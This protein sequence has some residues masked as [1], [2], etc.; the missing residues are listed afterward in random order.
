MDVRELAWA[1]GLF[2]ADGCISISTV[3][4]SPKLRHPVL[5]LSM[6]DE[7]AVR[8]FHRAVGG[9]GTIHHRKPQREGW[10]P[11]LVWKANSF[12]HAQAV[13]A[14][15]WYG[16]N[17]RRRARAAEVFGEVQASQVYRMRMR[18]GPECAEDDCSNPVLAK[19]LCSTHY[20]RRRAAQR[21]RTGS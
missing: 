8:R 9:V 20:Q 2:D 7:D 18:R 15:L 6:T 5:D 19:G 21:D 3:T 1:A 10:R 14:L 16:L 12:E 13:V 17:A 4:Q 11:L